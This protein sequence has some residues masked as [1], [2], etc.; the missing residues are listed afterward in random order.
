MLCEIWRKH[1]R[2]Y[3]QLEPSRL[4]NLCRVQA[5]H[6]ISC[7]RLTKLA[8]LLVKTLAKPLS[9]RIKHDFSRF[10]VTKRLLIGIGQTSHLVTSRMQIWSAGYRVR[11][12]K[13][14][15]PEKELKN[16]AE[17]VGETFIFMVSGGIVIWEYNRSQESNKQKQAKAVAKQKA[18]NAALQA[19]LHALDVRLKAVEKVV[20]QNS[21]SILNIRGP[22][23]VGPASSELVPIDEPDQEPEP[24]QT[25]SPPT[26]EAKATPSTN[27]QAPWW[28]IW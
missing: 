9:K 24:K 17:L 20:Q 1:Y 3:T 12:I 4:P 8:G 6:H 23:Y 10:D 16:G 22:K 15:E 18:E 25:P 2:K 21:E 26:N 13:P 19:K 7:C 5:H 27:N 14:L 28:K 11:S